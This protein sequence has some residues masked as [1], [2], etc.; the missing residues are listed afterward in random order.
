[1]ASANAPKLQSTTAVTITAVSARHT[2]DGVTQGSG[3]AFLIAS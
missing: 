1:M 3:Y 2:A